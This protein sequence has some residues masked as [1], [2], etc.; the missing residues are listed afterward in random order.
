MN[1]SSIV[2]NSLNNIRSQHGNDSRFQQNAKPP[3]GCEKLRKSGEKV[4]IA[5]LSK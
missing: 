1:I 3:K 4:K 5:P 2:V